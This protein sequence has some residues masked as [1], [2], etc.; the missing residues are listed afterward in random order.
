MNKISMG[1]FECTQEDKDYVMKA[2]SSNMLSSGPELNAFE[3]SVAKYHGKQY[4][5]MVNS[6]Q[7]ALEVAILL[8]KVYLGKSELKI[9]LPATTYA[10]TLWSILNQNCTPIFCDIDDNYV[11][12]YY[13]LENVM[14]Y[15]QI[16][17]I[18]PVDLCGYSAEPPDWFKRKNDLFIIQD[19]CEAFGNKLACYGDIICHS[20]YVSH[21][22]T[23]GAG[24][25]LSLNDDHLTNYARSY[26]SHGRVFGGDF[27]KFTDKWVDRFLFD[28]VGTSF[29]SDNLAAAL[30]L[31]QMNRL[32]NII[33]KR[34]DNAAHLVK[35]YLKSRIKDKYDFPSYDYVE[36][37]V[38]QF[39]PILIRDSKINREDLLR[40]LYDNHIDSRVLLSLTN[41]PIIEQMYGPIENRYPYAKVCN[42]NGFIVG[43]H[44]DLNFEDME[45]IIKIL[46]SYRG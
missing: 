14:S 4:G 3:K 7:S 16:D 19:A 34:K 9:A 46:E 38:F 5:V 13:A 12:D 18:M 42:N 44:Q 27:T 15:E 25:M 45:Y 6:G 39:F 31:S 26:I 23:T 20:F 37:S 40:Y 24:G 2:L 35:T 8:A 10:S 22:I 1:T 43:C 30:G 33:T 28:K 32:G 11:I 17:V 36:K 21:I 41:Q 29:R